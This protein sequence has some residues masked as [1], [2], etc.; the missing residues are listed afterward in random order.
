MH[1][2]L[3][4]GW[5][6]GQPTKVPV[7][8]GPTDACHN[9]QPDKDPL[10]SMHH[11]HPGKWVCVRYPLQ[12]ERHGWKAGSLLPL[13]H[14]GHVAG[15]PGRPESLQ[16][17]WHYSEDTS[18][19]SFRCVL[20]LHES[21]FRDVT[22]NRGRTISVSGTTWNHMIPYEMHQHFSHV[23]GQDESLQFIGRH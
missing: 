21:N 2:V 19:D 4:F 11:Q 10:P 12:Q 15:S 16:H 14:S 23:L 3:G 13:L 6:H 22:H 18:G 20:R 5:P 7:S 8:P 1:A 9:L 17:E